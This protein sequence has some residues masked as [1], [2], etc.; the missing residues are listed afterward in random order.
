MKPKQN[1][2]RGKT[3][4]H[5]ANPAPAVPANAPAYIP[6]TKRTLRIGKS[7]LRLLK[8]PST[9]LFLVAFAFYAIIGIFGNRVYDMA[10]YEGL[11]RVSQAFSAVFGRNPHLSAIGFIWPPLPA[12][13]DIPFIIL[14]RPFHLEILGGTF[15]SA[16]YAGFTMVQLNNILKRFKVETGW[17][18]I[19][20]ALFGLQPLILHNASLGMSETPFIG[21]LLFSLNGYLT[22]RQ[23]RKDSGIMMAGMGAWLALYCRYEALAWAA[24]MAVCI[25]WNWLFRTGKTSPE[26]LEAELLSYLVPPAYGFIFWVFLNWTIMGDPLY[27]LTGPGAT[28]NTPD[29]AQTYGPN[30]LWYY[31][32]DS[33]GG[34]LKLLT[35]EVSFVGPLLVVASIALL[36]FIVFKKR[37]IDF[38]F[39]LLGWSIVLFT[40]MIGYRGYLPAFSRYFI[41]LIPGGLIVTGAVYSSC[42]KKWMRLAVNFSLIVLMVFPIIHE[43]GKKWDLIEEPMPQKL[44]LSWI[45]AGEQQSVSYENDSLGEMQMIA[46]YLNA[47]PD[48]TITIVDH[49]IS[50]SLALMV[51]H[52]KNLVMTTDMDFF[53]ILENPIGRADQ[54]LVPYPSFDARGRSQVLKYYPGIY[55]GFETWTTFAHE[56]S[57]PLPWRLFTINQ[58]TQI[59]N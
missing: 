40:C 15:M 48:D 58:T 45:I 12:V 41:W 50:M 29:T 51:D 59:G 53:D 35:E 18:Y 54:I 42:E 30:H 52:P 37:W 39:I 1:R 33:I 27:F 16:L 20:L 3:M 43:V 55:E 32:M 46:D 11:S 24:I 49:S 36:L 34:T 56:F 38:D 22:W 8:H 7:L 13:S 14:L 9:H 6:E 19:W 23:E 17:R 25:C 57:S 4:L 47:Q 21:F 28:S 26:K 31:A 5:N 2:G 10:D 44:L